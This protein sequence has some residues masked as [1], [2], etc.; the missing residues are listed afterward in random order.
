L[1]ILYRHI[2]TDKNTPFYIGIG[3]TENR[4]YD[5]KCRTKIWK[6]IAKKGY[7]TEILFDDLTWEQACEKEK[8]FIALYGRRDLGTGTLVN[9]TDGGEGTLGYRHTKEAKEKNRLA[10]LGENNPWYNK[11]RPDQAEKMKGENNPCFGRV[12]DKNPMFGKPGYWKGKNRLDRA[13]KVVYEEQEFE[14]QTALAKY[15]NKSKAYITK[16]IKHSK[17]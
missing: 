13:K 12:G 6:N 7:E 8:E 3:E 17:L 10:S 11:K 15:L 4:A 9:L 1:A 14:S 2:R 16:L 5:K